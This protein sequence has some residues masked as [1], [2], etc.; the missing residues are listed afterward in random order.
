MQND[1]ETMKVL[2]ALDRN[3]THLKLVTVAWDNLIKKYP[4]GET[5]DETFLEV[6]QNHNEQFEKDLEI[7]QQHFKKIF[8]DAKPK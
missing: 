2:Q 1:N 4:N 6:L 3:T 8:G 5:I 7:V